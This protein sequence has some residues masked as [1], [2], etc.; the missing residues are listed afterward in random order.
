MPTEF[1]LSAESE[2]PPE[3]PPKAKTGIAIAAA[4]TPANAPIT[5][6]R[7]YSGGGGAPPV[8]NGGKSLASPVDLKLV[9][10][11][12]AGEV[13][14]LVLAEVA[15]GDPVELVVGEHGRC[16]LRGEDLAAVARG[17][18][19]RGA[20][21]AHPVVAALVGEDRLAGVQ[22]HAH[23]Q[24]RALGPVVRRKRALTVGGR[25]GGVARA[26]ED[27]EEGVAL[28]I[29]LLAAVRGERRRAGAAGALRAR[30]RSRRATV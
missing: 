2:L 4:R 15:D 21:H 29:D 7:R 19:P 27:V 1:P 13:L 8:V 22:A 18:D 9:D 11:L 17:H 26:R 14:E 24:L 16:R 20:V 23:A 5:S 6:G 3:P 28:G 30:C 10:P 25:G 12:G